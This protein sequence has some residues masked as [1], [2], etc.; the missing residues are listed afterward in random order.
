MMRE[1]PQIMRAILTVKEKIQ[2][3]PHYIRIVLEGPDMAVFAAARV[4]DN[5]K[6]MVGGSMRTYTCRSLD[7]EKGL[8]VIDFVSHGDNGP[9]S[10]WAIN[11]VPGDPL[12][13]FMK[14]KE[15][16][17]FLPADWYLLTGDHTAL[18]VISVMLE[19]LPA[20]AQGKAIL[21]VYSQEDILDLKKPD[22]V[23]IEWVFNNEPGKKSALTSYFNHPDLPAQ[24]SKFVF[25]A[26]E[27]AAVNEIQHLLRNITSLQRQE[28][29]AYAYWKFGQA[30][31]TSS[32]E[33]RGS[34]HRG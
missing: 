32:E 24:L 9:A 26:A 33:R 1:R 7:L 30:E 11:A 27:H 23:E 22:G 17:L 29:Q 28:W 15:K 20:T 21:E 8:M 13:V 4:G 3:T 2:L 19:S 25:V 6:I 16:Q 18:P 5:N 10:R 12:E 31:E 34:A 14:V